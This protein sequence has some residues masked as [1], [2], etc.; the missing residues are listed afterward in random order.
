MTA[1]AFRTA[2]RGVARLLALTAAAVAVPVAAAGQT[3]V[4]AIGLG[5]PVPPVDARSA[6]LGGTGVG[7]L[8][9]SFSLR[10]PAEL[11]QHSAS[12]ISVSLA[13]EGADVEGVSGGEGVGRSR[14]TIVRAVVPLDGWA[15]GVG[16][17]SEFDQ[18][19][20]A[21]FQDTLELE[22]GVFPFEEQREH[23]GGIGT[24]DLSV[25]R[26]IGPLSVGVSGQRLTGS[27]RQSLTRRFEPDTTSD[28][29]ATLGNVVDETALSYGGWRF[30]AGASLAVGDRV[31]VGGA[32]AWAG[33]LDVEVGDEPATGIDM[34]ASAEVGLSFRPADRLLLTAAG[35]WTGWGGVDEGL[36]GATGVDARWGG[37]GLELAG[38]RVLGVAMP[39]RA[40]A[41]FAELPFALPDREQATERAATLGFGLVFQEGVAAADVAFELGTRGDLAEAGVEESFRRLTVS[42]T[43]RQ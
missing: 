4:T 26:R 32:L 14:F 24:V 38:A 42:F 19:W 22:V 35:G 23:D 3:P 2:P 39:L 27:L 41:R 9:G 36:P 31:L 13:P 25:A 16:F 43:I 30:R 29:D 8:D 20:S 37:A 33:E 11:T 10:N 6:A 28:S 5:Y 40:G 17:G 21:R 1:R 12:G 18:D 7:L 15:V 34:P